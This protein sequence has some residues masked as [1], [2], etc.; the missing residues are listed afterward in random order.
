MTRIKHTYLIDDNEFV[1]MIGEKSITNHPSY[2]KVSTF[3]NGRLA[4]N[5][6]KKCVQNNEQLPDL[7]ILDVNMPEMNGWEF[8]DAFAE[9]PELADIPVY[10]FTAPVD[11]EI[12][13]KAKEFKLIKGFLSK[14]LPFKEIDKIAALLLVDHKA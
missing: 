8:L 12:L 11:T 9:T 7:I 14:S 2:D 1:L 10:L 13:E 6:L 4:F 5:S 3:E